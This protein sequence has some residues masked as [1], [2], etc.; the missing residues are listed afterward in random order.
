MK[1]FGLII[2]IVCLVLTGC[3]K[4]QNNQ[5]KSSQNKIQDKSA[6]KNKGEL[7]SD[8]ALQDLDGNIYKLSDQ[9]GKKV[10]VK[11]WASWCPICLSSLASLDEQSKNQKD[12]QIVTVVSPGH[13]GEQKKEDFIK[14]FKSLN[15]KNIKVLLDDKGEFIKTYG[16]RATPTN[17]LVG[18]DGVLIK[19]FAGQLNKEALNKIYSE[20]K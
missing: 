20:I 18:S 1:K 13:L 15:Y 17:V 9:K 12:Y 6:Q 11:F 19:T 8:F 10:Y 4:T 14:W 16:V 7:A 3:T 2:G 5:K